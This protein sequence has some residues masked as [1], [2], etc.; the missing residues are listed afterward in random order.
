MVF[1][2]GE[3]QT[4]ESKDDDKEKEDKDEEDPMDSFYPQAL[5]GF[6][7]VTTEEGDMIFLTENV[8]KHIGIAQVQKNKPEQTADDVRPVMSVLLQS[9]NI[10][11]LSLVKLVVIIF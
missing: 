4:E 8:S 2:T 11:L 10:S 6:I 1:T 3:D 5:A 9:F 7:M